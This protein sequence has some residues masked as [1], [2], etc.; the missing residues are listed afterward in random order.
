MIS[1]SYIED[2]NSLW[3]EV[4]PALL[5]VSAQNYTV[6]AGSLLIITCA[7]YSMA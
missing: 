4:H 5:E 7:G 2:L 6:F 3:T 1:E